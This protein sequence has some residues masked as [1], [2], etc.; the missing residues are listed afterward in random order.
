MDPI[1]IHRCPGAL[2]DPRALREKAPMHLYDYV[3]GKSRLVLSV[4]HAGTWLPDDIASQLREDARDLRDTDWFVP[5][6][7]ELPEWAEATR[8]VAAVSRYVVDLNRPASDESLYPGQATT[9]VCP[10]THFDGT[11][12]YQAAT[13][14]SSA[15]R[16]RRI[17]IYWQPY[18]AQLQF[19]LDETIRR[20]G[21]AVLLDAHSIASRVPRLFEG[22]LPDLNFGTNHGRSCSP[23]LQAAIDDFAAR[24]PARGFSSVVNGRFVGGYITRHYGESRAVEAVQLEISQAAYLDETTRRWD[25]AR[26]VRLQQLLADFATLLNSLGPS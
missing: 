8:L 20:E 13:P 17:A 19:A 23:H 25:P 1:L 12:V 24:L 6:L 21:W 5:R 7:Y 26:A 11:P 14:L 15:E 22:Q 10:E 9:G 3:P 18:H 4:P 16:A 2:L